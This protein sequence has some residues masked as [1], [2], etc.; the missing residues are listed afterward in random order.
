MDRIP[1]YLQQQVEMLG[2]RG[3]LAA[4]QIE[5]AELTA[6]ILA[7]S[8]P[9]RERQSLL[10]I[11]LALYECLDVFRGEL[12]VDP[13]HLHNVLPTLTEP[14]LLLNVEDGAKTLNRFPVTAFSE[15]FPGESRI[16][17][18][19]LEAFYLDR[20]TE[21]LKKRSLCCTGSWYNLGNDDDQERF[22]AQIFRRNKLRHGE[23]QAPRVC[24]T[25]GWVHART[26]DPNDTRVGKMKPL[27]VSIPAGTPSY[28]SRVS[29]RRLH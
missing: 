27:E 23:L 3:I 10:V 2:A 19:W 1:D 25:Y 4:A 18:S 29:L 12:S 14:Y 8:F 13:S 17:L 15:V 11:P 6:R 24:V 22:C 28:G 20:Q 21:A 26:P 9:A 16:G 5:P 7:T